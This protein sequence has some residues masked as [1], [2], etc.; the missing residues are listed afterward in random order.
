MSCAF[1]TLFLYPRHPI[2]GEQS[3]TFATDSVSNE[4]KDIFIGKII[5]QKVDDLHYNHS[6]FARQ[7]HCA[8]SS[9]YNL[10]NSKD[11]SVEKLLLI[12]EVLHYDFI[13]EVYLKHG[14][15]PCNKPTI[16]IPI[17]NGHIDTTDMPEEVPSWLKAELN[18]QQ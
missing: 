16:T 2:K 12:S 17:L 10:F 13:H 3:E 4:L 6:D 8:R 9:L 15:L 11:I 5:R 14:S 7:I 18:V 1:L